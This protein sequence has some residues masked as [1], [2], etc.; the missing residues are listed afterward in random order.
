MS[1]IPGIA[2]IAGNGT[3]G[4]T[5]SYPVLATGTS[6]QSASA[7]VADSSGNVYFSDGNFNVVWKVNT[8]GNRRFACNALLW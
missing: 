2:T 6:I 3:P 7:V 1:M 8:S 5:A 4:Y